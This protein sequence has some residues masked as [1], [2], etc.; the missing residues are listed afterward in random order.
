MELEITRSRVATP[1]KDTE[2]V[3]EL[4]PQFR[5]DF[6]ALF[7]GLD[8]AYCFQCGVCSSSCPTMDKM[9]YGPRR[10]LHMAGLGLADKV[11]RSRDIWLCVSCYSCAARC[12]QGIEITEAMA[13]LR[14]LSITRGLATDKEAAFSQA[15]V[16][17]LERHGRLFEPE[18]M[19]RYYAAEADLAAIPDLFNL[20]GLGLRMF[21]K[22]KIA[23]RPER[24]E[25]VESLSRI[26]AQ[27]ARD[28][29]TAHGRGEEQ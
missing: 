28:R 4:D 14:S 7:G 1:N 2:T 19:L 24:I 3:N 22:R 13:T 27:I 21:G 17:V 20:A 11:L 15:F 10:I 25:N 18:L 6:V 29:S 26:I 23:L 9:E 5:E 16:K 8:L 12:P